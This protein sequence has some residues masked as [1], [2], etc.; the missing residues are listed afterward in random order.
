MIH[1]DYS[2]VGVQRKHP[3]KLAVNFQFLICKKDEDDD[4]GWSVNDLSL[5]LSLSLGFVIFILL[6]SENPARRRKGLCCP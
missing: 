4:G 2:Y 6:T 1:M 3:E 5:H